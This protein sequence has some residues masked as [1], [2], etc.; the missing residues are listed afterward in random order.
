MSCNTGNYCQ[1]ITDDDTTP[2]L[3][4]ILGNDNEPTPTMESNDGRNSVVDVESV[5]PV[6]DRDGQPPP[7]D[8]MKPPEKKVG[9]VLDP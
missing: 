4:P 3:A 7:N 8:L 2:T 6:F 9:Y 1:Q 5:R